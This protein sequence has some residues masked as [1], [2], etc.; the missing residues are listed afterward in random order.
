MMRLLGMAALLVALAVPAWA[1][2]FTLESIDPVFDCGA[3]VAG[4]N[5]CTGE[6]TAVVNIV[7]TD[8]AWSLSL[9][10]VGVPECAS[11]GGAPLGNTNAVTFCNTSMRTGSY[12]VALQ[13]SSNCPEW[14]GT[15]SSAWGVATTVLGCQVTIRATVVSG[16]DVTDRW[17]SY[18]GEFLV[19]VSAI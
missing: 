9:E 4:Q 19:T 15:S 11:A 13:Y 8:S 14:R 1:Q 2:T 5:L 17:G 10:D 3:V 12:V 18:A 6:A 7:S 16:L